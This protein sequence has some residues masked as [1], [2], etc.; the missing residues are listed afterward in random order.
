MDGNTTIPTTD[1]NG[2]VRR[3]TRMASNS[4]VLN[5]SEMLHKE[6]RCRISV[7]TAVLG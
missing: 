7:Q 6:Y 2:R 1:Q 5:G 4:C 3:N